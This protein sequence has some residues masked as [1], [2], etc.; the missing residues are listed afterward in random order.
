MCFG[1]FDPATDQ[2]FISFDRWLESSAAFLCSVHSERLAAMWWLAHQVVRRGCLVDCDQRN[3]NT[4]TR[5]PW[6]KASRWLIVL[7]SSGES[8]GAAGF[9]EIREA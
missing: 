2:G 3:A 7:T 9:L 6:R 4:R 8:V 5:R 1:A